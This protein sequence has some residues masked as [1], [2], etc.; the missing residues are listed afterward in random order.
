MTQKITVTIPV[1]P[2]LH[3]RRWLDE[4]LDSIAGQTVPPDEVLL[5]D[6]M[7]GLPIYR[8]R[9][10]RVWRSPWLLGTAHAFNFGVALAT[11]ELVIML[12][13]DDRLEPPAVES[14]LAQY[15]ASGN[16]DAYYYM[17]FE[18][19]FRAS[20]GDQDE[21]RLATREI[22]NMAMVTKGLWRAT[23]GFPLVG[24]IGPCDYIIC[25]ALK[26]AGAPIIPI[27]PLHGASLCWYRVHQQNDTR[28]RL[29][30]CGGVGDWGRGYC[31]ATW[32]PPAWGRME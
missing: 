7:A 27:K 15:E 20:E 5:I 2:E 30:T 4:C 9:G 11:H 32:K 21:D 24:A 19:G 17:P 28:L 25:V 12:G 31:D 16:R 14:C 8:K 23:G 29:E 13:S 18:Y 26:K 10:Y 1:G 3:H 22:T 6:D